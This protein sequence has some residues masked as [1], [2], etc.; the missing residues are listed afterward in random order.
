MTAFQAKRIKL[1]YT[2]TISATPDK[3]FPLLCP[4]REKDWIEGWNCELIYSRTGVAENNCVFTTDFPRGR[5]EV[6]TVSRY[7]PELHVIQFVI[8][9]PEAYVMKLDI[10]LRES[11]D[12]S[13]AVS[14]STTFTGLTTEGNSFIEQHCGKASDA[15]KA[16]LFKVLEHYCL[17]GKMLGRDAALAGLHSASHGS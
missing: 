1:E 12:N 6:W 4:V 17:T 2:H 5:E 7:E 11:A 13:T 14:W 8:V 9:S 15:R 16:L 10:S 3:I